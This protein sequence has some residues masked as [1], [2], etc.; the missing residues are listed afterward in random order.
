MH[1]RVELV[2]EARLI[3]R[4]IQDWDWTP[5]SKELAESLAEPGKWWGKEE[6]QR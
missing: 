6:N 1:W 5:E 2:Y 3:K 4:L